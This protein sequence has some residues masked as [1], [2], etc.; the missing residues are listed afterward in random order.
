MRLKGYEHFH[1]KTSN[2][3]NDARQTL[4]IV[5]ST[6]GYSVDPRVVQ[7]QNTLMNNVY[8]SLRIHQNLE[9]INSTQRSVI[10]CSLF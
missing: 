2:N 5:L 6:S 8:F 3:Q 7:Y 10:N 1:E 4:V 9:F